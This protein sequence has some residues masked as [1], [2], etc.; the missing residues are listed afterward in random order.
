[1]KLENKFMGIKNNYTFLDSGSTSLRLKE[2]VEAY[3]HYEKTYT[4]NAG[5]NSNVK[6]TK[7]VNSTRKSV[8]KF[9]NEEEGEVAFTSNATESI[10]TAM[11]LFKKGDTVLISLLEHSSAYVPLLKNGINVKFYD[12]KEDGTIDVESLKKLFKFEVDGIIISSSYNTIGTTN[13][14]EELNEVIPQ[15]IIR[16]I[17]ATQSIP[18]KRFDNKIWKGDVVAFSS[19]KIFAQFGLGILYASKRVQDKINPIKFGGGN[20]DNVTNSSFER[21][22]GLRGIESGTLNLSA[23]FTLNKALNFI[24]T[25]LNYESFNSIK[26]LRDQAVEQLSKHEEITILNKNMDSTSIMF[27]YEDEKGERTSKLNAYLEHNNIFMRYGDSCVKVENKFN[28]GKKYIRATFQI[29]N[30]ISDIKRI[31]DVLKKFKTEEDKYLDM[32]VET[33]E[34]K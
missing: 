19:H 23:I 7:I 11:T 33:M 27:L 3:N 31:M 28:E 13:N 17:D 30:D 16:I 4:G 21:I 9:L 12:I 8:K 5:R 20:V 2:V 34:C 15:N 10:N 25:E 6:V 24:V 26:N 18:Y 29:Y 32:I 1:M 14:P 22:G